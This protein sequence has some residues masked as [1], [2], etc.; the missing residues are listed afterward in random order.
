MEKE[1]VGLTDGSS[2]GIRASIPIDPHAVN[3]IST[4]V[5]VLSLETSMALITP[6]VSF[7]A[8]VVATELTVWPAASFITAS[9]VVV[10]SA[11]GTAIA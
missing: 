8:L 2:A 11:G 9:I 7:R 4:T 6:S 3:V 10:R 5:A 1:L